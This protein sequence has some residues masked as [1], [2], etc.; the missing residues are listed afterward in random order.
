MVCKLLH[1][2]KQHVFFI[3]G[4]SYS[5]QKNVHLFYVIGKVSFDTPSVYKAGMTLE[6]KVSKYK[7]VFDFIQW[8]SIQPSPAQS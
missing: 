4:V 5:G 7:N 2:Y 6:G 8:S 1:E 3:T